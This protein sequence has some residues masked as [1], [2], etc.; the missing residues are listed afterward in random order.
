M[1]T[2]CYINRYATHEMLGDD[3]KTLIPNAALRRRMSRFVRMGVATAMQ[4]L[5][6]GVSA[7][8]IDTIVTATG[9]GCLADSEKFLRNLIEQD[10]ELLNPTPF[11]QSTFNTIGAQV[12]LLCSNHSYNMTYV[13]RGHSFESALLD[14]AMQFD[15]A[16][17]T[18]ALVGAADEQT[19]SQHR[20]MERMGLWRNYIDGE[21]AAFFQLSSL[22]MDACRACIVEVDFPDLPQEVKDQVLAY[23]RANSTAANQTGETDVSVANGPMKSW[24][25]AHYHADQIIIGGG[26]HRIN[27]PTASAGRLVE[28]VQLIEN[29]ARRVAVWN[30]YMD[31]QSAVI[32]VECIG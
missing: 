27:Y 13:H 16:T 6:S 15:D 12:A 21:G 17:I 3:L 7:D 20:I 24:I 31:V 30:N 26:A 5:S 19:P 25:K 18:H 4:C 29:G 22:P 10:E 14:V 2:R 1:K 23:G 28:A 8:R 11:I 32:V 9:W